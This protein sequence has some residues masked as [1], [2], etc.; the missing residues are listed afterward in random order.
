LK[1]LALI[2]HLMMSDDDHIHQM[3]EVE[4]IIPVD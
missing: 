2:R 4:I 3:I 1:D